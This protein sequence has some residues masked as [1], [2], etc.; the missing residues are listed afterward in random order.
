MDA[1]EAGKDSG[2]RSMGQPSNEGRW[3]SQILTEIDER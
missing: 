2:R 3:Y 1:H